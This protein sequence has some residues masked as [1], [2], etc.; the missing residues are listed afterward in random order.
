MKKIEKKPEERRH[1]SFGHPYT[2]QLEPGRE[3]IQTKGKFFYRYSLSL[4]FNAL[5]QY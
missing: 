3:K 4:H 1:L 5:F 2:I